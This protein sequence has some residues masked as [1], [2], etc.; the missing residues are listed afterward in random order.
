MSLALKII[1]IVNF[2]GKAYR[3]REITLA[4]Q[5]FKPIIDLMKRQQMLYR[6]KAERIL[7]LTKNLFYVCI[8]DFTCFV[9]DF[10]YNIATG[11]EINTHIMHN[12]F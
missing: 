2:E 12:S 10:S 6:F 11:K 5:F 9:S 4:K 8:V 3:I 7:S 1:N